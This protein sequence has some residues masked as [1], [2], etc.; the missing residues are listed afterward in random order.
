[1]TN[2]RLLLYPF[3]ILLLTA[4]AAPAASTPTAALEP[5]PTHTASL[6]TVTPNPNL[7]KVEGRIT[8]LFSDSPDTPPVPDVTF[9]LDRHS[10]D[11][12]K[13]KAKSQADGYYV[14][15]NVEP[16]EY[17]F[18]VYLNLKLD[19]RS[20]GAPEFTYSKDLQW[21]HYSTWSKV[22]VWYDIIFSEVDIAVKP[23]E[24]ITLDF[25][26]KCP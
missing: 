11:Y 16:G 17:G 3:L 22:N 7:G 18:G 15:A 12:L 24:T 25:Q 21:V 26:L 19:E 10:G 6:P 8:W 1:M 23:G 13:Y 5:L 9:Q 14:F 20:C 4:C 2:F